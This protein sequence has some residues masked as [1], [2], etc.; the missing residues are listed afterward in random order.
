MLTYTAD[1]FR[2]PVPISGLLLQIHLVVSTIF[3]EWCQYVRQSLIW[4]NYRDLRTGSLGTFMLHPYTRLSPKFAE[5]S[6]DNL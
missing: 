6:L 1:E 4:G 2:Q 5:T 3:G